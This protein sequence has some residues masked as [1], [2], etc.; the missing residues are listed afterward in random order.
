MFQ[1]WHGKLVRPVGLFY[2]LRVC[3]F[4]PV[5][6]QFCLCVFSVVLCGCDSQC[7]LLVLPCLSAGFG[8]NESGKDGT[9]YPSPSLLLL[10]LLLTFP[11]CHW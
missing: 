4:S 11:L 6:Y 5:F 9:A 8:G 3:S 10:T 7:V 1:R 2:S